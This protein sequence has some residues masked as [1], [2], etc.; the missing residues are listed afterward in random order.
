MFSQSLKIIVFLIICLIVYDA[1]TESSSANNSMFDEEFLKL[2]RKEQIEK[3]ASCHQS[4]HQDELAGPHYNAYTNLKKHEE[5]VNSENYKDDFYTEHVNN[6]VNS[7]CLGCHAPENLFETVF[8]EHKEPEKLKDWLFSFKHVPLEARKVKENLISGV[9]CLTCHFD[10][11][12]VVSNNKKFKKANDTIPCNPI[13]SGFFSDISLTC[14][15]CHIDEYK[16]M[17]IS[18]KENNIIDMNCNSCHVK[19]KNGEKTHYYYWKVTDS[20]Q[21]NHLIENLLENFTLVFD[22]KK[23]SQAS[24]VFDNKNFPHGMGLCPELVIVLSI[25]DKDNLLLHEEKIRFNRKAEFDDDMFE[26]FGNKRLGG[27]IGNKISTFMRKEEFSIAFYDFEKAQAYQFSL[28]KKQQYW[29][30]DSLGMMQRGE[31]Y[32]FD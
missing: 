19:Q 6:N 5:I 31:L 32:S 22:E 2:S 18:F 15:P 30:P 29:F 8:K 21:S 26:Y 1:C 14:Y 9:D 3:C 13:Y 7:N 20:S 11:K 12:S 27:E 16:S 10:G 23:G 4:V 24:V 17:D 25:F 28:L